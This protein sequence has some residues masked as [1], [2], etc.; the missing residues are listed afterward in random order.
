VVPPNTCYYGRIL[1]GFILH[2]VFDFHRPTCSTLSDCATA[3]NAAGGGTAT[4]GS[5]SYADASCGPPATAAV[6]SGRCSRD[7]NRTC[8]P[9]STAAFP[10]AGSCAPGDTCLTNLAP[11]NGCFD[12]TSNSCRFTPRVLVV[13]NWG[14]CSGECRNTI[15]GGNLTDA[16]GST[17]LHP[18]GGCYMGNVYGGVSTERTRYNTKSNTLD[19]AGDPSSLYTTGRLTGDSAYGECNPSNTS[20]PTQRPWTVYPGALELR[21]SS[22]IAP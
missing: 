13:D 5:G 22:E 21:R 8:T 12:S 14:W 10:A 9:G 19:T 2:D 4:L 15:V 11:T 6:V 7:P 20:V 18:Y 16:S 17:V 1:D 3:L